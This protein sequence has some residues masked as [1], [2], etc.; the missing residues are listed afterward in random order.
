MAAS[1][2]TLAFTGFLMMMLVTME[3]HAQTVVPGGYVSGTW[4]S[5]GSPFLIQDDILVHPD[6]TL[7]ITAGT[8]VLFTGQFT[9][10]VQGQLMVNG[11]D[12]APVTFD[13]ENDTV[14]WRGIF[15]NTTDTSITDSSIIEHCSVSHCFGGSCLTLHYSSRVRVSCCT[16]SYG[17]SFRGGGINCRFSNPRFEYLD[18]AHHHALDGAG[19]ALE[20]SDASLF[21]C[22]VQL[23]NAD[24]AGGGIVIFDGSSP[25]LEYCSFYQNTS[26]GSGGGVYVNDAFPIFKGCEFILN[27]GALAGGIL[28]SGGGVSV[29]LDSETHFENC[30]FQNNQ[31]ARSGGAIASFSPAS[32]I[33]CLFDGNSAEII[34]GSIFISSGNAISSWIT[35]CTLVNNYAPQGSTLACYNHTGVLRNCILWYG[36][37]DSNSVIRLEAVTNMHILDIDYSDLQYGESGIQR[38]GNATYTFG[39]HNLSVNPEME[40]TSYALTW[41][42]PCIDAGTPDTTG[43]GIPATDLGGFPRFANARV[44]MG[45]YEYQLPVGIPNSEFQIPDHFRIYPNPAEN[46]VCL[47]FGEF[48]AIG[49]VK[50]ISTS[51]V[52]VYEGEMS[53]Q[54]IMLNTTHFPS[55][56]YFV[57]YIDIDGTSVKK[58]I[59]Y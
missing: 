32:F 54:R 57:N 34:G 41:N 55:G 7:A 13:R 56:L 51:G 58:L 36:V 42:S 39:L 25:L 5:A 50:I 12:A 15:L 38:E 46:E 29:K 44:D 43:L 45:A 52:V 2:K 21:R 26:F 3:D 22:T 48:T 30:I 20:H 49:K 10:E 47:D 40:D 59:I 17:E 53:S 27:H 19:I 1:A 4:T 35:N 6:S 33:N 11:T 37:P 18:V 8:Q 24:G 23:N 9:L 16:I 14:N 28:Y 31:S